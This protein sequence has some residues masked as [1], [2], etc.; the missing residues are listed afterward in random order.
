LDNDLNLKNWDNQGLV[1]H[2][3]GEVKNPWQYHKSIVEWLKVNYK[4]YDTIIVHGIWLYHSF[5]VYQLISYLKKKHLKLPKFFIMPHGMLDPWFQKDKT[6]KLKAFRNEIYWRLIENIVINSADGLL[7]TCEQEKMLARIPFPNYKPKNEFVVGLGIKS[8][9]VFNQD[10]QDALLNTY[11]VLKDKSYLLFLSRVD[12]KKGVDLLIEAYKN[13]LLIEGVESI[14]MLV[15]AGPGLDTKYG[16]AI[17]ESVQTDKSLASQVIF[18]GMIGGDVKWGALYGCEAFILPSHQENFGIAVVE[19][20]ACAKP[21]LISNQVNI[22]KE[23][24]EMG[25]GL[26]ENDNLEGTQ[27]LIHS[28]YGLSQQAKDAMKI[29]AKKAYLNYFD[30]DKTVINLTQVILR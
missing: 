18:T 25:G 20:L 27:K 15:I 19:A 8:P 10:M 2:A 6:R 3:L 21:V 28:Y 4:K 11:P 23:I 12:Y 1:I 14:P 9:P 16:K 7:F 24:L 22:W 17:Y 29:N 5:A 26:I 13:L 30:I